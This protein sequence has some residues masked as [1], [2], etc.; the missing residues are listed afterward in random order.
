M[1]NRAVR[2]EGPMISNNA[3]FPSH[4]F[5]TAFAVCVL[6]ACIGPAGRADA[7]T[8]NPR[9]T[10]A[11]AVAAK[12]TPNKPTFAPATSAD[13]ERYLLVLSGRTQDAKLMQSNGSGIRQPAPDLVVCGAVRT[14]SDDLCNTLLAAAPAR[15]STDLH[16]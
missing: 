1:A 5:A 7:Q 13:C 3:R 11:A 2:N 16:C 9:P 4:P 10:A 14:N 12:A 15:P 8:S 6:G